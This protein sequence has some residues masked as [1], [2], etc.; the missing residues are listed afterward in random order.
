VVD[1]SVSRLVIAVSTDGLLATLELRPP[2][3]EL[4]ETAPTLEAALAKLAEANVRVGVAERQVELALQRPGSPVVVAKAQPPVAGEDGTVT[5]APNL[6]AVAGRPRVDDDGQVSLFDLALVHNVAEGEVLATRAAP[7]A[8]GPGINVRGEPIPS[9][10]G[11]PARVQAGSGTHFSDDG[12]QILAAVAGHAVLVG[13]TIS[14][15]NVYHVRGDVGP[16]TGHIDFVGSVR[17]GGSVERGYRVKASGD[18]EIQGSMAGGDVE[19]GGNVSVRYGIQGR[20][21]HGSVTAVGTVRAK[22]IEF[23]TVRAGGNVYAS[24]GIVH[25]AVESG[26]VVEVL[27]VHGSIIGG[28]LVARELIKAREL[29]SVRGVATEVLVGVDP[30]L[31]AEAQQV[32][33]RGVELTQQLGRVQQRLAQLQQRHRLGTL[34]SVGRHELVQFHDLYRT[35]LEERATLG[36]R[37]EEFIELLRAL[38]A[39]TVLVEGPCYPAVRVSI[40]NATR[41]VDTAWQG[42]CFKRNQQTQAVDLVGIA[43]GG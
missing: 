26:A 15:S 33:A 23:A 19:A 11:K 41:T 28:R 7:T 31:I 29:G 39:A 25:S 42:V 24:D 22:F 43:A 16:G 38:P 30:A 2:N 34:N 13:D 10:P 36:T 21:G 18:V 27:G 37:Q 1:Q 4:N 6:L 32:R 12:G 9:R 17:I 40:G 8:G 5:Y 14:V 3:L 35:F 20:D